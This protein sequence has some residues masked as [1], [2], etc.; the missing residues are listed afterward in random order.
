MTRATALTCTL[1][2]LA[3]ALPASA[4][5]V[6]LSRSVR[7]G[8]PPR[9]VEIRVDERAI[10]A[11]RE[12]A[13]IP[14]A[15]EASVEVVEVAA[16]H[17]VAVVRTRGEGEAA[18][19]IALAGGRPR[20]LWSERTDLHGDPGERR[21]GVLSLDDRTG[22]G[23]AD[24]VV[25][26]QREGA[27]LCGEE[28]T[29]LAPRAFDPARGELRPVM[30]RRVPQ[31]AR[32][33]TVTATRESPGPS[34]PPLLGALR[35]SGASSTAGLDEGAGA[36]PRALGDGN[37]ETFWAEGRGG[38]GAGEFVVA[39]FEARFPIRA[40]AVTAATGAGRALGRPRR[41]WLVGD[42]GPPVRV[43]MPEDAGLHPGE[44]YWI[45]LPEP[46]RWR[47]VALVLDEAY[48]PA[49]TREAA[50]HTGLGEL[51]AYTA[52]DF[53]GGLDDLVAI[54]IEGRDGGDDAARLLADLGAPAVSALAAAWE[55]LDV[56]GKRRAVRTFADAARRGAEGAVDALAVAARDPSPEVRDPALEALGTLEGGAGALSALVAEPAPLGDAAVRPLLRHEPSVSV[57]ALLAALSTEGGSERAALRE[58]LAQALAR[59]GDEARR[60]FDAWALAER[61]TGELASAALGLSANPAT[62]P[63]A[64]PLVTAAAPRATRFED[65]WRLVKAAGALEAEDE[66][67]AWLASVASGAEEWMLRGAALEALAQR[68]SERRLEAARG[69]LTDPYPRVRV[70]AIEVL[71]PAAEDDA[72]VARL[73]RGDSWPMVR[74][75]AVA[76]LW[77]RPAERDAVRA[78]VRDR[79]AR[80]RESAVR[81]LT[82]A[83]D[84]AA[85]PLVRARL[86]DGDEWPQVTVAALEYVRDLCIEEASE[87][88]VE[89]IRRGLA[90]SPWPPDVDVAA[91]AVDVAL[92]LGG[93]AAEEA[94]RVEAREDAPA[95]MRAAARRRAETPGRCTPAAGR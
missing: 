32:A 86:G 1:A 65:R 95:S 93:P 44:R 94:R 3:S 2:L 38:P 13:D 11:G 63:L 41:F 34:G 5:A 49:G 59:A 15:R 88:I 25:G 71:A 35:F 89:V 26:V 69:A 30:L 16:G 76:A 58:G 17:S 31:D 8:S 50:V 54:L 64:G 80:V 43:T 81:A 91:L 4:D 78:A 73:A 37:P 61:E 22:D 19:V 48:A 18:A 29:L 90:P 9:P 60:P 28:A 21:A 33:I 56:T 68:E 79:S 20:I 6:P 12:R 85:W 24:V 66:V 23:F 47:C 83:G 77:D 45:V 10:T 67:D 62:R 42:E 36:P 70:E 82:R 52:L 7:I 92:L 74:A 14:A 39:R 27:N 75:A 57:P 87:P 40:F 55:R 84:R 53:G 72:A 46:R 51:E